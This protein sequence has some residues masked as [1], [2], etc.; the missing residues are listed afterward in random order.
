ML[1][2]LAFALFV[3]WP[4]CAGTAPPAPAARLTAAAAAIKTA[5]RRGSF[6][7][8]AIQEPVSRNVAQVKVSL[9]VRDS[10]RPS[11]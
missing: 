5:A 4:T 8:A 10:C 3:E 7:A 1:A 11:G 9:I 6:L 2:G